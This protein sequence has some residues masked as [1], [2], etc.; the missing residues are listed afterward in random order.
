M[1]NITKEQADKIFYQLAVEKKT[2][3]DLQQEYNMDKTTLCRKMKQ[4]KKE[5]GM[6]DSEQY[7]IKN[8]LRFYYLDEIL[9]KYKKG[10]TTMQLEQ[11]YAASER[12]FAELI[13]ENSNLL[14][15][16][17]VP[18]KTNQK[19]F[20]S[21]TNEIEAYTLGLITADGCISRNYSV[22]LDMKSTDEKLFHEINDRLYNGTGHIFQYGEGKW[23]KV[24]MSRLIIH[25]KQ[26]CE[27]LAK[28]NVIPN[29][30]Y[31]LEHIYIFD[32]NILMRHYL[33]GLFDGDGVVSKGQSKYLG[34]GY[35]AH[36]K[37]FTKSFQDYLCMEL[38][39]GKNKLF[40]C[41]GCWH[42]RWTAKKDVEKIYHFLYDDSTIC[43]QR[44]KDKIENYLYGNTEVTN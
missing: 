23:H 6:N 21:I 30:A 19:L 41:G 7:C 42:C 29:K 3:K 17:G 5:Y 44:K 39:V 13:K 8:Y 4:Y 25:G 43:L 16:S 33:R 20:H 28:Y 11:Y 18:S 27:N 34:V 36:N 37:S 26:I 15:Q 32:D 12:T 31:S 22:S 24:P 35:C 40:D 10:I 1:K 2:Y 14:R 9:D 38:E